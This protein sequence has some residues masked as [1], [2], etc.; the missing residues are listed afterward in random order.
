MYLCI[1]KFDPIWA[2][3]YIKKELDFYNIK[4]V[5]WSSSDCG[6]AWP[7]KRE[8]KIPT[9]TTL[10]RFLICL[11][12]IFHVSRFSL[13]NGM[14]VYEYEFDCELWTIQKAKTLG[15]DV[16][17]YEHRARGY[18]TYCLARA[19]NRGLNL[20]KA[21]KKIIDWLGVDIDTWEKNPRITLVARNNWKKW[22][23]LQT[24]F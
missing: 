10:N 18:I 4:V 2:N 15:F 17:D 22:Y 1:M 8:V 14:K 16:E 3:K 11:H 5:A 24:N 13:H 6:L 19:Y 20:R 7:E 12:E 21:N 9:P 23:V